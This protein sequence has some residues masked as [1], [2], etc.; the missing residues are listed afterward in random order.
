VCGSRFSKTIKII[1]RHLSIVSSVKQ[2]TGCGYAHLDLG[3]MAITNKL[4]A[5]SIHLLA[6]LIV[7]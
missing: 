3:F 2:R 4:I 1:F 5:L 7:F 6:K